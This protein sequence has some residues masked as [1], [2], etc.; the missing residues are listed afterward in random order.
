[1]LPRLAE[2]W[3][4]HDTVCTLPPPNLKSD[5]LATPCSLP[6]GGRMYHVLAAYPATLLGDARLA[7]RSNGA[8]RIA[9]LQGLQQRYGNRALQ[10]YL[11]LSVPVQ[12]CG[13]TVHAGC[14]CATGTGV[15]GQEELLPVQRTIAPLSVQRPITRN[16][17]HT[18]DVWSK[19]TCGVATGIPGKDLNAGG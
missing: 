17:M 12:R 14:G 11:R 5:L 2:D 19:D 1:M 3:G 6:P 9:V 8:V 13:N 18:K 16:S 7:A 4:C 10:R 15:I